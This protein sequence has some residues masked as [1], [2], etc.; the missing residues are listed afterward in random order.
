MTPPAC[1]SAPAAPGGQ[2]VARASSRS[3]SVCAARGRGCTPDE[4]EAFFARLGFEV[5]DRYDG[6]LVLHDGHWKQLIEHG[7][8]G[9]TAPAARDYGLVEFDVTDPDGNRVRIGSPAT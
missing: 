4:S 2:R 9:V 7:V 5:A 3:R 1:S 6:Y 8:P